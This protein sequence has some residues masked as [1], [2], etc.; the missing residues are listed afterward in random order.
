MMSSQLNNIENDENV[1]TILYNLKKI[2]IKIK[3]KKKI[4]ST[5]F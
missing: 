3:L 4:F 1:K 2:N 5:I